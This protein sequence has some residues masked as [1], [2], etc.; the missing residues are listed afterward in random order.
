M[1]IQIR[2]T[3][4]DSLPEYAQIPIRFAVE[5]VF[6]V[7]PVDGGLHGL[8][9]TEKTVEPYLKDYDTLANGENA[10]PSWP[11]RFDTTKWGVFHAFENE[12]AVAGAVVAVPTVGLGLLEGQNNTAALWDIRVCPEKRGRGIGSFLLS[13]AVEWCRKKDF[14]K[15]KIETQNI[16][17]PACRFY[18]K[19][20]AV[21]GAIDKHGYA[22]S[23][24]V[25]H[26]VLLIWYLEL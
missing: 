12:R 25:E 8:R 16:N 6:E 23:P 24:E 22:G 19:H 9:L 1:D 5:S 3:C 17:V 2:E 4:S 13:H 20:G 21:L 15:L 10:P 18:A 11:K 26:E 14:G 7:E